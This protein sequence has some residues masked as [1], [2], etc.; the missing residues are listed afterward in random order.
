MRNVADSYCFQVS[1]TPSNYFTGHS[2]ETEGA[3]G[4]VHYL[5]PPTLY[6]AWPIPWVHPA[7]LRYEPRSSGCKDWALS[8][9]P[10]YLSKM[11][12]LCLPLLC[13]SSAF[14]LPLSTLC[15]FFSLPLL[16]QYEVSSVRQDTDPETRQTRAWLPPVLS[17]VGP[18]Y[19]TSLSCGFL[20][21]NQR[22][23]ILKSSNHKL[24]HVRHSA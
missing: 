1:R 15:P 10:W 7:E 8:T 19:L 9:S 22:K 24:Q 3:R 16:L 21:L 5:W 2:L 6:K 23:L 4:G 12:S 14:S 11:V 13:L 18:S 20:C 17:A